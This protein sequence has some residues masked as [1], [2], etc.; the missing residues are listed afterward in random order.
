MVH[1]LEKAILYDGYTFLYHSRVV[2]L[3]KSKTCDEQNQQKILLITLVAGFDN[4]KYDKY[5]TIFLLWYLERNILY[6]MEYIYNRLLSHILKLEL[7]PLEFNK[8]LP[9]IS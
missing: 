3:Q 1:V 5:Q 9:K 4:T 6:Y 7:K 2:T 8:N